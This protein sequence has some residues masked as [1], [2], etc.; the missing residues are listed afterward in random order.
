MKKRQQILKPKQYKTTIKV[1]RS[2]KVENDITSDKRQK[3]KIKTNKV[4]DKKQR[5]R[6]EEGRKLKQIRYRKLKQIR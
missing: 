4:S 6:E 1:G 3:Q 5:K 2:I